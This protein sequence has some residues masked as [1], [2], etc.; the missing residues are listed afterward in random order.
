M[1]YARIQL[2][3]ALY[4]NRNQKIIVELNPLGIGITEIGT[5]ELSL[6]FSENVSRSRSVIVGDR[7]ILTNNDHVRNL[8]KSIPIK[9]LTC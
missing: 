9:W 2:E 3:L 7:V 8:S 1:S 5:N 4:A 6:A